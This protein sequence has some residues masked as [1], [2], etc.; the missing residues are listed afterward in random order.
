MARQLTWCSLLLGG[1]LA[2]GSPASTTCQP[3]CSGQQCGDDGCGGSCGG[4]GSGATCSGAGVCVAVAPG[5]QQSCGAKLCGDDGC[6]GSCGTCSAGSGCD[7][8]KGICVANL[9]SPGC[10]AGGTCTYLD[11]TAWR[12]DCTTATDC[13]RTTSTYGSGTY[14]TFETCQSWGCMDGGNSRCGDQNGGTSPETYSCE[15]CIASCNAGVPTVCGAALETT[16]GCDLSGAPFG[17]YTADC[18]C[19]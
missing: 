16:A 12:Y 3:S 7:L 17:Q 19:Q 9:A 1:L 2:C 6:G 15:A 5:C 8:A 11:R 13:Q 14:G 18:I 10:P 4:C